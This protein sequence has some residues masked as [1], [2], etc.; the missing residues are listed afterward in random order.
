[1]RIDRTLQLQILKLLADTYPQTAPLDQIDVDE[2]SLLANLYY[3]YEHKLIL[4]TFTETLDGHAEF[5]A[6]QI[7][8]AGMD[9]LADDGGLSAIL[10]VVTIKLHEE[11]IRQLLIER[12]GRADLP[13]EERS[14]L[15][16]VIRNLPRQA[17][18]KVTEKLLEQGA[19]QILAEAPRLYTWL[20][21]LAVQQA[22]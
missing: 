4:G 13:E 16:R 7:T 10:G 8:A 18:G 3:L 14:S 9:F 19:D 22:G 21:Q 2:K 17:L 6:P 11:S 5:I 12:V 1:M 20:I 15:L